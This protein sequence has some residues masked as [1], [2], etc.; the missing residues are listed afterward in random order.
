M[1]SMSIFAIKTPSSLTLQSSYFKG[2][3]LTLGGA[4]R[5]FFDGDPI[6]SCWLEASLS[7][8][9]GVVRGCGSNGGA[10]AGVSVAAGMEEVVVVVMVVDVPLRLFVIEGSFDA[11]RAVGGSPSGVY[12]VPASAYCDLTGG[13]INVMRGDRCVVGVREEGAVAGAGAGAGAGAFGRTRGE[14]SAG[15]RWAVVVRCGAT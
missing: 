9:A 11:T 8:R 15:E 6:S 5:G 3:T 10:G 13:V 14:A 2:M 12:C 4:V 1:S 7:V